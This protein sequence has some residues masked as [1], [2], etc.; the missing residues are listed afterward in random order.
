MYRYLFLILAFTLLHFYFQDKVIKQPNGILIKKAPIQDMISPFVIKKEKDYV[1][2]IVATYDIKGRI[3]KKETYSWDISSPLSPLD[4][5]LGWQEMS[6]NELLNTVTITQSNRFY[7]WTTDSIDYPRKTI[8]IESSNNHLIPS[9]NIIEKELMDLH[10]GELVE[11]KGYLVNVK[12][13]NWHWNTSLTRDDTGDGA[14]EII[15]VLS[16]DKI[17]MEQ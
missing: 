11:I 7:F 2:T 14:C 15:Y 4:L 5:A 10:E 12:K 13:N 17:K 6:S 8:E 3:L 16:V 9:N 1:I